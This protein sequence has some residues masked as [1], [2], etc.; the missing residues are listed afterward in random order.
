[1]RL[2]GLGWMLAVAVFLPGV[3]SG[4]S[5]PSPRWEIPGFDFRVDGAF[6][7]WARRI[8]VRRAELLAGGRLAELNA[9]VAAAMAVTS[10]AAVSGTVHIPAVLFQF[11]GGTLPSGGR[12]TASYTSVLF[13]ASPPP[14][15]PYTVRTFY[16]QLSNGLLSIQGNALGYV[17]LDSGEN[18]Y[19]GK[20]GSCSGSPFGGT[21]CNG[22]FSPAAQ[23]SMQSGLQE[24]L[25]KIENTLHPDW[26]QYDFDSTTGFLNLVIFVQ[27]AVDGACG[28]QGAPTNHLWSH[29]FSLVNLPNGYYTTKTPWP[30]HG[31]QFLKISDYTLQSGVGGTTACDGSTIMPIGTATHETG[32]AFGL[33]DLYDVSQQSEGVGEWSL[34]G[35]GNYTAPYSPSRMDVWSLTQLGWVN[36]VSI[37]GGGKYKFGA[38]PTSDTAFLL[39]PRGSNPRGEYFLL[40]NRQAVYADTSM[41][42]YHCAVA[43]NPSGC[44]GGLLIWHIDSTMVAVCGGLNGNCVN[45]GGPGSIHGVALMQADGAGNLDAFPGTAGSNRGD[46]KDPFPGL[47]GNHTFGPPRAVLN[48]TGA[49]AGFTVDSITQVAP[50]GEMSFAV[51]FATLTTLTSNDQGASVQLDGVPYHRI[52]VLLDSGSTHTI[53]VAD[54]QVRSDSLVRY[55]FQS[56][57]DG[58]AINHSITATGLTDSISALLGLSFRVKLTAD[59]GGSVTTDRDSAVAGAYL[60]PGTAM[61]LVAHP[62]AGSFFLGWGGDTVAAD[63]TLLINLTRPFRLSAQ[64]SLPLTVAAVRQQAVQG[65]SSL[66]PA[67]LG[68]LDRIGNKNGFPGDVGDFLAWV[69]LTH[70]VPGPAAPVPAPRRVAVRGGRP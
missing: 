20:P 40:E 7:K 67:Q 69:R 54:T 10:S 8:A 46:A 21:N 42:A 13:G 3:A 23:A 17:T 19:A 2:R 38:A 62:H 26:A 35:S 58:G 64:F 47:T 39:R 9:P 37:P 45:V 49:F 33:P 30:G 25:Q 44:G 22:L 50:N 15:N 12:D 59:T 60:A 41:I 48:A 29:R 11:A 16:E 1:M 63:T 68:Y 57:S 51:R 55:V 70:A 66:T 34:M 18:H 27:P 6:R 36:V 5:R 52:Q 43:G 28:P 56:W 14:G 61:T 32:H 4:Q 53:A 31:S 65:T 24:A